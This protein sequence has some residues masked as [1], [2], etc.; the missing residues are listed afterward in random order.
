M[1]N[2][3]SV[4]LEVTLTEIIISVLIFAAAGAITLTCFGT[5]RYTQIKSNDKTNALMEVQSAFELIKNS[6][7]SAE[8][9]EIL[10][11]EFSAISNESASSYEK[12]YDINWRECRSEDRE[13]TLS[14]EISKYKEEYGEMDEIKIAVDKE[15][16]Y[17]FIKDGGRNLFSISTKKFYPGRKEV[18]YD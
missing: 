9:Q 14:V 2:K 11:K 8:A 18:R 15:K 1:K 16:K 7:S 5:A 3:S 17:P 13:F 4:N 10:K 12:Y 6:G